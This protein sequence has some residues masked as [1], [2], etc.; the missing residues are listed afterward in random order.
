MLTSH[1]EK[2]FTGL[3]VSSAPTPPTIVLGLCASTNDN[4]S[5]IAYVDTIA[6]GVSKLLAHKLTTFAVVAPAAAEVADEEV[7]EKQRGDEEEEEEDGEEEDGEKED[8]EEEDGEEEEEE[9]EEAAAEGDGAGAAP[10]SNK[11][12]R[13]SAEEAAAEGDGAAAAPTSN[14]RRRDSVARSTTTSAAHSSASSAASSSAPTK[15][16]SQGPEANKR[17]KGKTTLS[18]AFGLLRPGM[19]DACYRRP[20]PTFLAW[21]SA[22]ECGVER[23]SE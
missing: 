4:T 7:G 23:A 21:L 5:E 9:A 18:Q 1:C 13:D 14:K 11:R 15:P 8:G 10:T 20:P 19:C 3:L 2:K 12:S 6:N 17:A 22:A 16:S